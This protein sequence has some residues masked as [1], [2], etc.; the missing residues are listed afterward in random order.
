MREGSS[1][2]KGGGNIEMGGSNSGQLIEYVRSYSPRGWTCLHVSEGALSCNNV[3]VQNNDIGPCGSDKFQ[4]WADGLSI[5]CRNAV[6]KNNMIQDPTDGGIVLFGSPGTHVFNNTIW[7][8]NVR[9][10][11]CVTVL[12]SLLTFL[13][14]NPAWRYQYGGLRSLEW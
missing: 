5:S 6:I 13:Q 8:V 14:A 10:E 1:V 2:V 7:V 4:Q 9:F 11:G 12:R 3:T